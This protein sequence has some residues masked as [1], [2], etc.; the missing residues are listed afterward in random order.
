MSSG[1]CIQSCEWD[2]ADLI[3]RLS[4]GLAETYRLS[5]NSD[6]EP[7]GFQLFIESPHGN[8]RFFDAI[9]FTDRSHNLERQPLSA[10]HPFRTASNT[11]TFIAAA[12]LRLWEE[13]RLNLDA[14]IY[15]Y[16]SS[17]HAELIKTQ[18]YD[19]SNIT[20]RHLLTHTSGL[21]DYADSYPFAQRF[22]QAPQHCWTRTEQLQMA[23]GEGEPYGTPGE[24]YRYS[25]TGYILLGEIIE[26]LYGDNLGV[27]LRELLKFQ[28]LGLNATWLEKIENPPSG[29]LPTVHQYDGLLDSYALDASFDIYGGGG[30]VSTV[31]DLTRFMRGLFTRQVYHFDKTLETMLSTVNASRGGPSAYGEFEQ[32]PGQ[33]RLGIES[34]PSSTIY[35]HKGYFGTYAAYIPSMD[36]AIALSVN[37]HGGDSRELLIGSVLEVIGIKQ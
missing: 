8:F 17:K 12:I 21:F 16:I 27:A 33:Y 20:V 31:G 36:L 3:Q 5:I 6:I 26:R 13:Q 24:V 19:I 15:T 11:K 10:G 2:K 30:L 25:D 22:H 32:V 18:G 29:L 28:Q 34:N 37:Q 7:T 9:G 35:S 23:M 4:T 1:P 14:S